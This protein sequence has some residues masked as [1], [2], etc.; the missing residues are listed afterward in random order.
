MSHT[1]TSCAHVLCLVAQGYGREV[2]HQKRVF[3]PWHFG[4][5]LFVPVSGGH[6]RYFFIHRYPPALKQSLHQ[7]YRFWEQG[8]WLSGQ[9]SCLV[10]T[11]PWVQ[12]SAVHKTKHGRAWCHLRT[13][14]VEAETQGCF[15]LYSIQLCQKKKKN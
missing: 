11:T 5:Q 13:S 3:P 14:E 7:I 10:S 12:P 4:W 8:L 1:Q 9:D 6:Y 2:A 15:Q